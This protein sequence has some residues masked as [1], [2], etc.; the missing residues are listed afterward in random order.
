MNKPFSLGQQIK[1]TNTQITIN[2]GPTTFKTMF[3][4]L[5]QKLTTFKGV[6]IN[7]VRGP[8][9]SENEL[10]QEKAHKIFLNPF[11]ISWLF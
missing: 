11:N 10:V 9:S 4:V 5:R 8:D 3:W 1:V 7:N 6:T 2:W